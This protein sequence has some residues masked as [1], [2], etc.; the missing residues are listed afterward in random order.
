MK[1][2]PNPVHLIQVFANSYYFD[3]DHKSYADRK[4]TVRW[5]EFVGAN[6]VKVEGNAIWVRED[7]FSQSIRPLSNLILA[8]DYNLESKEDYLRY[9]SLQGRQHEE[10]LATHQFNEYLSRREHL[11]CGHLS[12][13]AFTWNIFR[14]RKEEKI[15]VEL[16]WDYGKLGI[17]ERENFKLAELKLD[18]PIEVSIDGKHD[19]SMTGRRQRTFVEHNFVLTYLGEFDQV[20]TRKNLEP[21]EKIIP[22][23]RKRINLLKNLK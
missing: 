3:K 2:N 18:K 21:F 16:A 11:V 17:P 20:E 8:I 6:A 22:A 14:F 19:F 9:E 13:R 10:A 5:K 7:L 15:E 1:V 23:E 4:E 12:S